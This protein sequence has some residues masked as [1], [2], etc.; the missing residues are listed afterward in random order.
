MCQ[1]FWQLVN[2]PLLLRSM[3]F[4]LCGMPRLRA[5]CHWLRLRAAGSVRSLDLSMRLAANEPTEMLEEQQALVLSVPAA[6]EGAVGG[7]L[8]KLEL[9]FFDMR[10]GARLE[11][12]GSWLL[13]LRGLTSLVLTSNN[14]MLF[15]A[16]L[17][18]LS[19]LRQLSTY[20]GVAELL[21]AVALPPSLT[22]LLLT[23]TVERD[24]PGAVPKQVGPAVVA[25]GSNGF[26]PRACLAHGCALPLPRHWPALGPPE[27]CCL[28][29]ASLGPAAANRC[30]PVST[31]GPGLR[32]GGGSDQPAPAPPRLCRLWQ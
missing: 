23:G 15:S 17:S 22:L 2:S 7:G 6:C 1:R 30:E 9:H 32:A 24:A 27:S 14:P 13:P 16:P 26:R 28:A 5:L 12:C 10:T 8:E 4:D 20:C 21:P 31:P 18:T 19:N 25:L 3:S 29:V 11:V